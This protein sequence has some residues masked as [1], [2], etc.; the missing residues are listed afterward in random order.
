MPNL[1]DLNLFALTVS[2]KGIS[3]AAKACD[4]QRSKLSRRL[5]AL[6]QRL[7]FQ[8]LIRTTRSIELTEKGRWLYQ[9]VSGPLITLTEVMEVLEEQRLRPQ[10]KLRIA[11]PPVMGVTEFFT[12]VIETYTSTYP[13]VVVE[14]QHQTQAI[15]LRRTN[16][17]IQIL[18]VYHQPIND[19][20][21]QQHLVHLPCCMVAAPDYLQNYGRP[22]TLDDLD[23][24]LLLGSRYSKTQLPSTLGYYVYSEDLHLLRNLAR[25]GKG[26]TLLPRVMVE[27]FLEEKQLIEVFPENAFDDLQIKLVYA[28]LPYLTEKSRSMIRLLRETLNE[29]GIISYPV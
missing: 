27:K 10:G 29:K 21:V 14:I 23:G 12:Q 19:D 1:D 13:D 17:D 25:D 8:L 7:G 6:E 5:Q 2:H 4:I 3:S 24:H 22:Q 9:Q 16:T 11:I 18:P 15:D 28:S 26:M 20:Y